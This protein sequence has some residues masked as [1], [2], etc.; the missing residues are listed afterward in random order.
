[1]D[2]RW[3]ARNRCAALRDEHADATRQAM[4]KAMSKLFC[5][6]GFFDTRAE[7]IAAPTAYH[8]RQSMP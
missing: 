1:M 5:E 3:L 6:H 2:R 7:N 4:V 8:L